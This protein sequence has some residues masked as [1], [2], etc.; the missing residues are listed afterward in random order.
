M[1][2]IFEQKGWMSTVLAVVVCVNMMLAGMIW[3]RNRIPLPEAVPAQTK[4]I[5]PQ[6]REE[7]R[8]EPEGVTQKG[9]WRVEHYREYRVV[10]DLNGKLLK[11]EPTDQTTNLRYW[12]DGKK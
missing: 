8:M 2:R 10:T 9:K 12:E 3:V 4:P 6:L 7:Y 1:W 5:K 11:K